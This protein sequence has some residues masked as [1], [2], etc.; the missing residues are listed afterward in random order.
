MDFIIPMP[1]FFSHY[2][3]S[4]GF[5]I[6]WI[7]ISFIWVFCSLAICALLPIWEAKTFFVDFWKELVDGR[8]QRKMVVAGR[9]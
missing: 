4:K 2:I 1:M 3:F 7:V 9:S 6:G 5:F 8:R